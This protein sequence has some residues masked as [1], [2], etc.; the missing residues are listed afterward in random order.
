MIQALE[1]Y[2]QELESI[3]QKQ[4]EKF[5]DEI[6]PV[7]QDTK[8]INRELFHILVFMKKLLET[9]QAGFRSFYTP[10][11]KRIQ[12]TLKTIKEMED[13]KLTDL[14]KDIEKII[15]KLMKR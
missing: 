12:K 5:E 4:P 6:E 3:K 1:F 2:V 8:E 11:A 14:S 9:K 7:T 13:N 10:T 15:G